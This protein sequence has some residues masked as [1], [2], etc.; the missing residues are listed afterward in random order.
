[1]DWDLITVGGGLGGATLALS[2][3]ERG[4]RVM[5]L[6]R[7]TEF[8]DRVRGEAMMP[9]GVAETRELGIYDLLCKSCAKPLPRLQLTVGAPQPERDL[10]ET[11]PHR[12]PMLS[13]YHPEM[14]EVVLEAAENA[15]A[16]VRRGVTV[17]G[18]ETGRPPHVTAR[19][20]GRESRFTARLVVGA[21][22]RR[23]RVRDWAGFETR[24]EPLRN[25]ICGLLMEGVRSPED[26][27]QLVLRVGAGQGGLLF[28]L[29]GGR[30]RV[31]AIYRK[32]ASDPVLSGR[33]HVRDFVEFC[34]NA[35]VP[36]DCYEGAEAAGPL[37][38]FEGAD[39]WVD[40]PYRE[41]VALVGDAA[42]SSDPTWGEGLALT[43]RDVRVLRDALLETDDWDAAGHRYADEHDRHYGVIHSI[44][45]WTTDL[46]METGPLADALRARVLPLWLA[47]PTRNPDVLGLGPAAPADETA[48][49]RFFGEDAVGED[50]EA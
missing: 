32:G 20:A 50:A 9:W 34:I 36:A 42:A 43:V 19:A 2:M 46:L 8:R 44:G 15:G 30:T 29:P 48:R 4:A 26:V 18:V 10:I 21:D 24:L 12:S 31:Y 37:A 33:T 1:M 3:A 28:P 38:G 14:Q 35:G 39:H 7:E 40:H 49:R 27:S 23:S 17:L 41:G 13:F 6:E 5:V 22:G 45:N 16:E 47:D 25:V 11:T